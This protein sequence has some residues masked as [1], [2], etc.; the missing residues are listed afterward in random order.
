[1]AKKMGRP[2]VNIDKEQF[3]KLCAIQCTE[4]EIAG[5]FGCHI[6][7]VN[8]WC[9]RTY[10]KT[11]SD[12]YEQKSV[13]G[14]ISLRRTQFRLAERNAT[15]AIFLGKQY[16]GQRDHIEVDSRQLSK[17]DELIQGLDELAGV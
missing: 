10:K 11:F 5:F 2:R 17:V 6:D 1:M 3:E 13:P 12:I 16:L 4:Q 14:K 15:M 7:T 8:N 9:K